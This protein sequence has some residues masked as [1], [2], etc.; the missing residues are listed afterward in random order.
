[1]RIAIRGDNFEDAVVQLKNRNIEGAAAEIIDRND[2]VL[3]L[4]EA[5]SERCRRRLVDETKYIKPGDTASVFRG[6]ALGIVKIC[7]NGNDRF[8]HRCAEEALGV[9]FKLTQDKGRNLGRRKRLFSQSNAHNFTRL[10]IV[11]ELKRKQL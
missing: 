10:Q 5:V 3:F 4:V 8:R 11:G 7:W 1:M 9:A 6:L 2:S